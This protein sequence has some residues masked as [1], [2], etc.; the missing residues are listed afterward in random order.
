MYVNLICIFMVDY[1]SSSSDITNEWHSIGDFWSL[2]VRHMF[3]FFLQ[4]LFLFFYLFLFH[5][6]L[7]A[8]LILSRVLLLWPRSILFVLFPRFLSATFYK[9]ILFNFGKKYFFI[10]NFLTRKSHRRIHLII[11]SSTSQLLLKF[12]VEINQKSFVK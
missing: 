3:F 2:P 4:Y 8:K 12:L 7:N 5:A 1:C 11:S 9:H 6:S 10:F